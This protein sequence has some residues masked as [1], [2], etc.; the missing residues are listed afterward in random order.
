[1]HAAANARGQSLDLCDVTR[2]CC[3]DGGFRGS[4]DAVGV[5]P[6]LAH[7]V[8]LTV[9]GVKAYHRGR[10]STL[11]EPA[12]IETTITSRHAPSR[13]RRAVSRTFQ[14]PMDMHPVRQFA[15]AG[16]MS[17]RGVP[18]TGGL[19]GCRPSPERFAR[20]DIRRS[21]RLAVLAARSLSEP[22]RRSADY[23]ALATYVQWRCERPSVAGV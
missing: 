22:A 6:E 20:T 17:T 13:N 19:P 1:M 4:L 15:R 10:T 3:V 11:R 18:A 16:C 23:P 21:R 12:H 8:V 2:T 5:R 14:P 7:S 9:V